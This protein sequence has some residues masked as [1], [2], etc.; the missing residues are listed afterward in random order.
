MAY[1]VCRPEGSVAATQHP[2]KEIRKS[3]PRKF[4]TR[5]SLVLGCNCGNRLKSA[6]PN[7]KPGPHRTLAKRSPDCSTARLLR[8]ERSVLSLTGIT[9]G[10]PKEGVVNG[11]SEAESSVNV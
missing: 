2:N 9:D 4:V 5:T 6:D 11:R 8:L 1:P 10:I 7:P 3:R